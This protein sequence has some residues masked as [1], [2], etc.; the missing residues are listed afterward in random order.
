MKRRAAIELKRQE[1]AAEAAANKAA[2]D[3]LGVV[4]DLHFGYEGED[5][6][7][8]MYDPLHV[9]ARVECIVYGVR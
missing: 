2:A 4:G 3:L 7:V 9:K 6:R 1:V 8:A 5:D